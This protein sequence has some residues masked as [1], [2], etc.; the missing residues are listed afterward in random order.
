M[1]TKSKKITKPVSKSAKTDEKEFPGYP[2]YDA[3][4]DIMNRGERIDADLESAKVDPPTN[5]STRKDSKPRPLS[6]NQDSAPSIDTEED[7]ELINKDQFAVT[8]EDLEALG[9]EDL[10]LDMGADE[11]LKHRT[12]PVDFT[13][14]DLDIPGSELDDAAES[15]G[16]EDEENNG[17]S[18]GGDDHN[19][20]EENKGE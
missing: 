18:I 17:Y 19:D 14:K 1:K 11:E 2:L 12:R 8:E 6:D 7:E 3:S 15:T 9:P 20:L 4:E 10:S 16:S 13:G 5:T